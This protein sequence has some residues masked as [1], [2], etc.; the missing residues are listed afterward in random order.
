[1]T[2]AA[3]PTP[4]ESRTDISDGRKLV[5][6][7]FPI[8]FPIL[9]GE[10]KVSIITADDV[11][12]PIDTGWS[13][14]AVEPSPR[15]AIPEATVVGNVVFFTEPVIEGTPSILQIKRD[16]RV[17]QNFKLGPNSRLQGP[18][19]NEQL[20]RDTLS[21]QDNKFEVGRAL[22]MRTR[23]GADAELG[24]P[25][26]AGYV[27]TSQADRS[28]KW[29]LGGST[30][31]SGGGNGAD[32]DAVQQLIDAHATTERNERTAAI[33]TESN[34]RIAGDTTL[35]NKI[36]TEIASVRSLLPELPLLSTVE[37]DP[38][39]IVTGDAFSLRVLVHLNTGVTASQALISSVALSRD[40]INFTNFGA[41]TGQITRDK[42]L[43]TATFSEADLASFASNENFDFATEGSI[44]VRTT[45]T[46]RTPQPRYVQEQENIQILSVVSQGA[47]NAD[48][49]TVNRRLA[50]L[51]AT[52]KTQTEDIG[53]NTAA[54]AENTTQIAT[55]TRG[56]T[57]NEEAT[58]NAQDTADIARTDATTA[59]TRA[60]TAVTT[61]N[62]FAGRIT[63]A[64]N[65]A[66]EARS[67]A[68]D[69][70][71]LA[72]RADA[73]ATALS[74]EVQANKD[75]IEELP[76]TFVES[77]TVDNA[78]TASASTGAITLGTKDATQSVRGATI[79]ASDA[80]IAQATQGNDVG[81]FVAVNPD[82]V[83]AIAGTQGGGSGSGQLQG[84]GVIP[85]WR[86]A[87]TRP[88]TP[89]ATS[90]SLT[91]D[92]FVDLTEGWS[93]T[94]PVPANIAAGLD[95][96]QA[97]FILKADGTIS[98]Q[99]PYRLRG[100]QGP[101]GEQGEQGPAGAQG[102]AGRDGLP[103]VQG[104]QGVQG[105]TGS[106][107]PQGPRG[108]QGDT[109]AT[110]PTGP[111]GA[112]GRDG[113]QGAEGPAGPAGAAGPAGRD[114]NPGVAGP[115]GD[116][117]PQGPKG[118]DG[119]P[120]PRGPA[121]P[122]GQLSGVPYLSPVVANESTAASLA[123]GN[124]SLGALIGTGG[125]IAGG[126]SASLAFGNQNTANEFYRVIGDS[127]S[128]RM[129]AAGVP[130]M[131]D[132]S[133]GITF[134]GTH[135]ILTATVKRVS[136]G[137]VLGEAD[138]ISANTTTFTRDIRFGFLIE[139][140]E[141]NTEIEIELSA[142]DDPI[143]ITEAH[144]SLVP[145][146][147][148]K[149]DEGSPGGVG[150]TGPRGLQGPEG[151]QGPTGAA[152][153]RG[154]TGPAG[155]QG[156][157]GDRG[158]QGQE[159]PRG[160]QGET[161][162]EG[163]ASTVAGPQ[164]PQGV[165]GPRG[166]TGAAGP[167]G[168]QG[169][170]GPA[171]VAANSVAIGPEAGVNLNI[172]TTLTATGI[173][174]SA[175]DLR[176]EWM[177]VSFGH[178]TTTT[179]PGTEDWRWIRIADWQALAVTTAGASVTRQN[180][181]AVGVVHGTG[182]LNTIIYVARTATNEILLAESGGRFPHD[183]YPFRVRRFALVEGRDGADG[184]DGADGERG[185]QGL[186]GPA[187]ARGADGA[188]GP[189]GPA[190]PAGARGADGATGPEGP[191]GLQG[192]AGSAGQ[193]GA[194]G[195]QGPKGDKGDQGEPGESGAAEVT[196]LTGRINL[197]DLD[198]GTF[199][200]WR[201]RGDQGLPA[202][203]ALNPPTAEQG[204][205]HRDDHLIRWMGANNGDG[206]QTMWQV[207]ASSGGESPPIQFER[208]K[209]GGRWSTWRKVAYSDEIEAVQGPPGERGPQ[210][211]QGIQGEQGEQGPTGPAGPQGVAGA[212]G[213]Q[214]IRGLTGTT[215]PRGADGNEGPEGVGQFR[216]YNVRTKNTSP[217]N[218]PTGTGYSTSSGT[219]S[220]SFTDSRNG[221]RNVIPTF[222]NV[223]HDLWA[224][225]VQV[226]F[227]G[228]SPTVSVLGIRN[229]T[230]A[231]G[232]QGVAGAQGPRGQAGATGAT[233]SRGPQGIQGIQGPTGQ[234][235]AT[236]ATGAQGPAGPPGTGF[237]GVVLGSVSSSSPGATLN[238]TSITLPTS[239]LLGIHVT[240]NGG[241]PWAE[242]TLVPVSAIRALTAASAGSSASISQSNFAHVATISSRLLR[243][244]RTSN[245]QLLWAATSTTTS[246]AF[247][248]ISFATTITGDAGTPGSG[249]DGG[250]GNGNG[251]GGG[252]PTT[253]TTLY[254]R[255]WSPL[256]QQAEDT[257]VDPSSYTSFTISFSGT[258][259]NVSASRTITV[260]EWR[261]LS[262]STE[263][264]PISSG[265]LVSGTSSIANRFRTF[266]VGRDSGNSILI[267]SAAFSDLHFGLRVRITGTR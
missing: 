101:A 6:R 35:D 180:T 59:L 103:G 197:N 42:Q 238:S 88:S 184:Q 33:N 166:E 224:A 218:I 225:D 252:T 193:D 246:I 53:T 250:S 24:D 241:S 236:G 178:A 50:T 173:T 39:V 256:T 245:N 168:L 69:A 132:L 121:G 220:V 72:N 114:G 40:G 169:I 120:G 158:P 237:S 63:A 19:L 56:L 159:G 80:Q 116:T 177:L 17:S 45:V 164:G 188:Q 267:A 229:T 77:I 92:T 175:T 149:G 76:D 232:S 204:Y 142:Q 43:L 9:D 98:P 52:D 160:E 221:W 48:L 136:D 8:N 128:I 200:L 172:G 54:I 153:P 195:P 253:T 259:N 11:E 148:S 145:F 12:H 71:G 91:N 157:Q 2:V 165:Q 254:D 212:Q 139:P 130:T 31:T 64:S 118:D 65:L 67:D 146:A 1:M 198:T 131:L 20:D 257:N 36:D 205:V 93:R 179:A 61:A 227:R 25:P 228:S 155:A 263:G 119:D 134:G 28:V 214:G 122:S 260:R 242:M 106:T 126:S 74:G 170:Q 211:I 60:N 13:F 226:S 47:A 190:G 16:T 264:R 133:V 18:E 183:A 248:V 147:G 10:L 156:L 37:V 235:G 143:T 129:L 100:V 83:R 110:G 217:P 262:T 208:S 144:L 29:Q 249:G 196:I 105:E 189:Q 68:R 21:T 255:T 96:F 107:G 73:T 5:G 99:A 57:A 86:V 115:R 243:F 137:E 51:E 258:G 15:P 210:G 201:W 213:P 163:P 34:A 239:G 78:L 3:A 154:A 41:G 89:S 127:K 203:Q 161:G 215:G 199:S 49:T 206:I 219:L 22:K 230:G 66:N 38:P 108:P 265:I 186:Q 194:Q 90:Y 27:P 104:P 266:N 30:Q 244:G 223:T 240:D 171:G 209:D 62:S 234:R 125:T 231:T 141:A 222:S 82:Q 167:R 135:D 113:A 111:A 85:V 182:G 216:L 97:N 207:D 152:G 181:L 26:G 7:N 79:F 140:Q 46:T 233:G 162:P 75:A 192:P 4:P 94:Q 87:T 81:Q 109:G 124:S 58:S 187:G 44:W 23:R 202:N 138:E 14:V 84:L 117:G 112:D 55:N 185:P 176:S 191:R 150:P 70:V 123:A 261:A 32:T 251:N 95:I 102:P 174:P 247:T 151:E